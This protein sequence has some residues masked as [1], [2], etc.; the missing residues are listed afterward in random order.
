MGDY[1]IIDLKGM[2]FGRLTVIEKAES[3][4][5]PCGS[6]M[7]MWLCSCV[8]GKNKI[9]S[10]M[11]LRSGHTISCGCYKKELDHKK[12][13]RDL[14]G[15]RFGRLV[16]IEKI[17]KPEDKKYNCAYWLVRCDCG[18][19]RIVRGTS[20]RRGDTT[21][22]GCYQEDK[23]RLPKYTSSMNILYNS[24]VRGAVIRNIA[25]D[26]TPE[27][28]FL[29]TKQNCFYCGIEPQQKE[30]SNP[31]TY[32]HYIYNGIDR[33]D[34]QKDYTIDNVVPCCKHCNF[35]KKNMSKLEFYSWIKR[36]YNY[37]ILSKIEI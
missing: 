22:C 3:R 28:F 16:A 6:I 14:K 32:G 2:V 5:F 25:F 24:Y 23:T 1:R 12:E 29:L 19:E 21:S 8:C 10:G 7:A 9:V 31:K 20:L 4:K 15:K 17:D 37:S 11:N 33:V 27:Q 30:R 34:S 18:E 35:A 26:L 13:F 36:I